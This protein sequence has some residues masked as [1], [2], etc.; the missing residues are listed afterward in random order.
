MSQKPSI[1]IATP[2]FGG[3]VTQTYMQSI[4]S[5]MSYCSTRNIDLTLAMLGHD[6]LIT[7]SR[8]TLVSAFLET[9]ATHILFIDADI[10]FAPEQVERMLQA[11]KP[12]VAGIYPLKVRDW[13]QLAPEIA[14]DQATLHYVGE[15]L[16]DGERDG[17]FATANYAG[18]GFMLIRRDCVDEMRAS[19]PHLTYSHVHSFPRPKVLGTQH[20]AL[21]ECLI[22]PGTGLYLSEDFA[23]CY[24]YR[25]IGG[26]VWLDTRGNLT[27]VGS[28]DFV[29]H[30]QARFGKSLDI[31]DLSPHMAGA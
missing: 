29:G 9:T 18:T 14:P 31:L 27:H 11:Q 13:S 15:P 26:Q 8:N 10:G 2:C 20:V 12:L 24:R 7:R 6:S 4:I 1:F 16:S 25:A 30:P 22:E 5:L 19:Y 21:F 3:Q 28:H 17:D 23:F